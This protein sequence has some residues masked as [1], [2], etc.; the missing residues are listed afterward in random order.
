MIRVLII[1]VVVALLLSILVYLVAYRRVKPNEIWVWQTDNGGV[2]L[3]H[4]GQMVLA[5]PKQYRVLPL[6][7]ISFPIHLEA[8]QTAD[9][10][11]VTIRA[12]AQLQFVPEAMAVRQALTRLPAL[13][14]EDALPMAESLVLDELQTAVSH[15]TLSE[16]RQSR[17]QTNAQL[18]QT[19]DQAVKPLGLGMVTFHIKEV[20]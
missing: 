3:A 9:R 17:Q 4:P 16:I 10:E 18:Q 5:W 6:E 1:L 13:R 15:L 7:A 12:K 11:V 20:D 2:R 8:V 19:L 14:L